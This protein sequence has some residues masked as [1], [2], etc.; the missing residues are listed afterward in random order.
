MN[1]LRSPHHA[2]RIAALAIVSVLALSG[3]GGG[4]GGSS[5]PKPNGESA[6]TAAEILSDAGAAV[7]KATSV[8]LAGH[9]G[10]AS[11]VGLDLRLA[12]VGGSGT[13]STNGLVIKVTRIGHAA[14]F[15]GSKAFYLHFTNAA[16]AQ[17]LEG[18]WL[19]VPATDS[20]FAAFSRLTDMRVL[21]GQILKPS[22]TVVKAGSRIL[23]GVPVIGLRD[24]THKGTLYVSA[25]G[26]P[27]PME[28]VASGARPGRISFDHWDDVGTFTAP[29]HAIDLAQLAKLGG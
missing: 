10:G 7:A 28:I 13:V 1:S 29:A 8:H 19:K 6:K 17:L 14:Y 11:T 26:V 9:V 20:R 25:T 3:C 27:Y 18:K 16:A 24:K 15:T 4:S 21:L 5:A 22:G 2:L 23:H 12:R